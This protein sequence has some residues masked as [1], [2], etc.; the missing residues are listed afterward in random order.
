MVEDV[1]LLRHLLPGKST[2]MKLL[3]NFPYGDA[4]F[5]RTGSV[6]QPLNRLIIRFITQFECPMMNREYELSAGLIGHRK[7][8]FR[9]TVCANPGIVGPDGHDGQI[10]GFGGPNPAKAV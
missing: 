10:Y 7:R 1:R 2:E 3:A 4:I 8:L 9:I 6:E 5:C